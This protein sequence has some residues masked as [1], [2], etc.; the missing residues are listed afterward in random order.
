M[1]KL[2]LFALSLSVSSFLLVGCGSRSLDTHQIT[3]SL[4]PGAVVETAAVVSKC[5]LTIISPA[6]NTTISSNMPL[7]F[8]GVIDNSQAQTLGCQRGMFEGQAGTAQLYYKNGAT[9]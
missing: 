5:G 7:V 2:F 1:K 6:P 4:N 3:G 8:S 9:R